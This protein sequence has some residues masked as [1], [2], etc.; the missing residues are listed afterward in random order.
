METHLII[1]LSIWCNVL[2]LRNLQGRPKTN[3]QIV[4]YDPNNNIR[5]KKE[6]QEEIPKRNMNN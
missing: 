2:S 3:N 6:L 4:H 1:T 5:V